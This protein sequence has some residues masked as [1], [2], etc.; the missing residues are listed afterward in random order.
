MKRRHVVVAIAVAVGGL[1]FV[2]GPRYAGPFPAF[3]NGYLIDICLPFAMY[4]VLGTVDHP[5][6][7]HSA[8]RAGLTFMTGAGV[9]IAQLF[10]APLF[11]RTF[12]PLDLVAYAVGVAGGWA[13]E[14]WVTNRLPE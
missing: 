13:F 3:V 1:H 7:G 6:I 8:V 4:L 14:R 10:G 2:T 5:L 11:G 12:D 9:E